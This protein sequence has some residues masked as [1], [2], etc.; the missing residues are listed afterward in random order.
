[1]RCIY[2]CTCMYC[3]F[4]RGDDGDPPMDD[5]DT[6]TDVGDEAKETKPPNDSGMSTCQALLYMVLV[7][8]I[9]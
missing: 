3:N 7:R 8:H 5:D 6:D 9:V 1:M 2:M 4:F